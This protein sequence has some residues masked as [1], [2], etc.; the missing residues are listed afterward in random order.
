MRV[1]LF[2]Y[3]TTKDKMGRPKTNMAGKDN[4]PLAHCINGTNYFPIDLIG[5]FQEF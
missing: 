4:L 2:E 3:I 5:K 1:K